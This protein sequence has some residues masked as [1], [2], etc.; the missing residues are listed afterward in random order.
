MREIFKAEYSFPDLKAGTVS[1]ILD[2]L[3]QEQRRDVF[4]LLRR[5]CSAGSTPVEIVIG[6][7]Q[8]ISESERNLYVLKAEMGDVD[9]L[10]LDQK[11]LALLRKRCAE[12]LRWLGEK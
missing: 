12:T 10:Y 9:T 2:G 1:V 6:P 3:S 5:M 8:P 4:S 7:E 11:N